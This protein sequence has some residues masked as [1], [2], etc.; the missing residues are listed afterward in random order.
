MTLDIRTIVVLLILS[1]LLMSLTLA[2]GLH[3]ARG[4]GTGRWI[5]GLM[6]IT[7]GWALIA[8]RGTLPQIATH[9]L[10]GS[11][12]VAGLYL[13][14]SAVLEFDG[15]ARTGWLSWLAGPLTFVSIAPLQGNYPAYTLAISS[16]LAAAL[17]GTGACALRGGLRDPTR[18]ILAGQYCAAALMLLAR[19]AV[20]ITQPA[21][22]P[23]VFASDPLQSAT[24]ALLFVATVGG[25]I[26]LP[27]DAAGSLRERH[28]RS[29]HVGPADR[30][31][32]SPRIL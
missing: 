13:H 30:P 15:K 23:G 19:A 17:A 9:A 27:H 22:H 20:V 6:L 24:F 8:A 18:W 16:L 28:P 14:T 5:G 10:A 11:A 25:V 32:Q 26:R 1:S 31:A 7:A 12:L 3:R 4:L 21:T 2:V 29:R